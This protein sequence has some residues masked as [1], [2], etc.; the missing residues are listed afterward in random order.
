[1]GKKL[2]G[3]ELF[4]ASK[5]RKNSPTCIC[6]FKNI[7]GG[8]T[9]N[10]VKLGWNGREVGEAMGKGKGKEGRRGKLRA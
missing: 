5:M 3:S 9:P 1:M 6:N 4:L 8:Y 7:S 10:P 2:G